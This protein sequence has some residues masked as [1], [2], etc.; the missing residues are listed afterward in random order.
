MKKPL[1]TAKQVDAFYKKP[2]NKK[3]L[4]RLNKAFLD[5][6]SDSFKAKNPHLYV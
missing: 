6:M 2:E 4:E 5:C 1:Y 3:A